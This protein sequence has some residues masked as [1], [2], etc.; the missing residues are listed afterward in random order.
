MERGG[1]ELWVGK[2]LPAPALVSCANS[3]NSRRRVAI[4]LVG[5]AADSYDEA[6]Q[7]PRRKAENGA[8]GVVIPRIVAIT[9]A[10]MFEGIHD[11]TEQFDRLVIY[12]NTKRT[13]TVG[14]LN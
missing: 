3:V 6:E 10:D 2:E 12:L 1:A 9:P 4:R 14:S 11:A 5:G 13:Q 8:R 7:I